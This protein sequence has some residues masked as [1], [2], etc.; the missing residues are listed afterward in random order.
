[1][2]ILMAMVSQQGRPGFTQCRLGRPLEH[3]RGRAGRARGPDR[4]TAP[5]PGTL[6]GTT[7]PRKGVPAPPR[8]PCSV[9]PPEHTPTA[10]AMRLL[11]AAAFV[12][13]MSPQPPPGAARSRRARYLGAGNPARVARGVTGHPPSPFLPGSDAHGARSR[14]ESLLEPPLARKFRSLHRTDGHHNGR[15]GRRLRRPRGRAGRAP[16]P[17]RATAPCPAPT[18]AQSRRGKG[19]PFPRRPL[20]PLATALL[21]WPSSRLAFTETK[22][23]RYITVR[24]RAFSHRVLWPRPSTQLGRCIISHVYFNH[25]AQLFLVIFISSPPHLHQDRFQKKM[26]KNS[27]RSRHALPHSTK[28]CL[29]DVVFS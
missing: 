28:R 20:A 1:L 10:M 6:A 7:P 3:P 18:A 17:Y 8:A 27:F 24:G 5:L 9:A 19:S 29:K 4:A 14:R 21:L 11:E 13:I 2:A 26:A 25:V 22:K 16:G 23:W 12:A 15:L